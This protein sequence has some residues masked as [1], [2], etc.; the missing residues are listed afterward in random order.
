M[1]EE[2]RGRFL[3]RLLPL[4][5]ALAVKQDDLGLIADPK[6]Q[7]ELKLAN[8]TEVQE[9]PIVYPPHVEKWLDEQLDTMLARE[10]IDLVDSY[11]PA[12]MVT[13]LV[14]VPKGQTG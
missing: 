1:T 5:H 9:K 14:L 10:R 2:L 6:Y 13:A 7:Y 8:T 4:T 11:D 3:K 12:P